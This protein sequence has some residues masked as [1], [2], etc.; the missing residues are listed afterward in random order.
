MISYYRI[1]NTKKEVDNEEIMTITEEYEL[2]DAIHN[3]S[4]L[5]IKVLI[6]KNCNI[7][8]ETLSLL[9]TITHPLQIIEINLAE[10]FSFITDA[11]MDHL[12]Q[13][14]N[15]SQLKILNLGDIS[16]TDASIEKMSKTFHFGKIET[17][18]LYGNSDITSESLIYLG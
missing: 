5:S 1:P 4:I 3:K 16:I 15:L 18:I 7:N 9:W 8:D 10:N 2:K 11:G 12:C 17:L 14:Q 6:L 13:C